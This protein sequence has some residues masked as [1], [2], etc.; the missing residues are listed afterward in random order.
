[1][2]GMGRLP[3]APGPY[4]DELLSSWMARV[5]CRY[6]LTAPELAGYFGGLLSPLPIDDGAPVIGPVILPKSGL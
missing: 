5:A 3:V 2:M 4:H 6:G 1:M